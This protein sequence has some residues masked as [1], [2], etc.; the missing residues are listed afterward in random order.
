MTLQSAH[1]GSASVL[2]APDG[3]EVRPLVQTARGSVAT[4]TLS[5]AQVAAAVMH[6]TVEEIWFVVAGR[7]ELWRRQ[8][9]VEELTILSPGV[10]ITI[11]VGTHFQFRA[12]DRD[13]LVILGTTMPPWPGE[14]EAV[15]V[16]GYWNPTGARNAS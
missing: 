13:G 14:Q 8:G 16:T 11:P 10:A 9:L 6:R 7:G 4:F 1:V 2:I 12:A 15:P 5:P 3:S